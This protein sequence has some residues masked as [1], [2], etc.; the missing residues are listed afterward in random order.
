MSTRE[1]EPLDLLQGTLDLLIL[2]APIFGARHGQAIGH[3]I[4]NT[5]DHELLVE[6]GALF[7]ALQRLEERRWIAGKWGVSANNRGARSCALTALG[8]KQLVK[9]TSKWKRLAAAAIR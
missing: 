5:S 9:E 2:R 8:R 1:R 7:P 4:K 3:A 6:H